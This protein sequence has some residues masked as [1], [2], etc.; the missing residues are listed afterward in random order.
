MPIVDV[1][2][3]HIA[4]TAGEIVKVGDSRISQSV[5][6]PGRFKRVYVEE[7]NGI[8]FFGGK[9]LYELDPS[10]KKYL[11]L[12]QHGDRIRDELTTS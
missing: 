5:I 7:G 12:K 1:I 9:Q 4:R 11:S 8:V 10:N 3:Q 6:L 2:E